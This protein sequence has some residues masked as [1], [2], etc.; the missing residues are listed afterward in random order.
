MSGVIIAGKTVLLPTSLGP[1]YNYLERPEIALGPED[2]R[3]RHARRVRAI[4]AHNTKN[5]KT[6]LVPGPGPSTD[7]AGRIARLW[8]TDHRQAGAHL[9]V[10]WDGSIGCHADL[11][12]D[13]AYHMGSFNEGSIGIELYQNGEGTLYGAQIDAAVALIDWLCR[14]FNIQR[15]MPKGTQL[16]SSHSKLITRVVR[17]G[18]NCVGVFGHWHGSSAKQEDPGKEVFSA[19]AAAGFKAFDFEAEEDIDYW[20][21]IQTKLGLHPD[22]IPGPMTCDALQERGFDCGLYDFVTEIR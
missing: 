5:V 17:G 18:A 16:A 14:R 10:D 9:S 3:A 1:V 12:Y 22:G 6:R 8:S 7:L 2:K 11:L 13:A 19:L 21:D 4:G 15:Q 20:E